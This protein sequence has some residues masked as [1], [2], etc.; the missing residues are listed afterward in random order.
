MRWGRRHP[1][2]A[3]LTAAPLGHFSM[4]YDARALVLAYGPNLTLVVV[5]AMRADTVWSFRLV[6]LWTEPCGGRGERIVS[7]ALGTASFRVTTFRIW[8]GSWHT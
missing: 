2:R 3:C 7:P 6:A 5:P 8:H 4:Q 1:K